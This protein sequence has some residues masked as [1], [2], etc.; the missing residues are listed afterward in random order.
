MVIAKGMV[1]KYVALLNEVDP[2]AAGRVKPAACLHP[3]ERCIK[4]PNSLAGC[5]PST[6]ALS[7]ILH[8]TAIGGGIDA[9]QNAGEESQRR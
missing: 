1:A 3:T 5:G 2:I 6:Y 9:D 4:A 7:G 8:G